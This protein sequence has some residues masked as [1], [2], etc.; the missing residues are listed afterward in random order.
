MNIRFVYRNA[1]DAAE[2]VAT[3]RNYFFRVDF[4]YFQ[5]S[6]VLQNG[7]S[8]PKEAKKIRILG[9]FGGVLAPPPEKFHQ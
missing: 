5:R 7:G 2:N 8:I 9:H 6:F 4:R 3:E 1:P